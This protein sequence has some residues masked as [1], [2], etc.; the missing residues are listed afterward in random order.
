MS[1]EKTPEDILQKVCG[2]SGCDQAALYYLAYPT[3]NN[4]TLCATAGEQ[5]SRERYWRSQIHD[6]HTIQRLRDATIPFSFSDDSGMGGKEHLIAVP[7]SSGENTIGAVVLCYHA[8]VNPSCDH[9][10]ESVKKRSA[11]LFHGWIDF[12]VAEQSRPL[13]F[14]FNIA[15]AISASL[16]LDRVLLNVVEQATL[17]FR[18]K[19]SSLM[20]VDPSKNELEMITAYGCSLD[21]LDKPNVPLT[22]SILGR[23]VCEN[24]IIQ[25]ENV[26]DEPF[27][28]HKAFARREGVT[29]LMAAPIT[30]KQNALGVL[31]IYSTSPRR[32]QRSEMELLQT[33]ADHVA[34]AITNVRV[35]EQM[36]AMEEQLQVSA[37]LSTLGELA[38]GLAHEIRN[39]LAVINM[40]IHSWKS[41][42]PDTED[43]SHDLDV[44][45]QKISDLNTL[46]K[47]LLH[48]ARSRP[49]D[50]QP[51]NIESIV[52]RVLRLLRHRI[53]QQRVTLKKK[54]HVLQPVVQVDRERIEQAILNLLLNALDATPKDGVITVE[55]RME[56]GQ[57]AID[58]TDSGPGIPQTELPNLFKAFHTTKQSGTGLGLPMTRRMIEEH[59]GK[60]VVSQN[61]AEGATFTILLPL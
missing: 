42:P 8:E 46:V 29:A 55:L 49:L 19:M 45:A 11:A 34:I 18:A 1:D 48:L 13:S 44:V 7:I 36:L 5:K 16:D 27:Y 52:D 33:F 2:E 6:P 25:L 17:L 30:F 58:V 28:M 43:F 9:L 47:D 26:F 51:H 15:G 56:E 21:Y 41:S 37:K 31:N 53:R 23:V 10:M 24:R 38:A 4:L 57:F 50:L 3:M 35:H 61:T 20:L 40:L 12:L 59:K 14:L 22:G 32:W 39:P 60:V 54:V